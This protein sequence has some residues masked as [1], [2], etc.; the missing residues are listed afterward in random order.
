[1]HKLRADGRVCQA[2]SCCCRSY[3]RD[4]NIACPGQYMPSRQHNIL[5]NN[6]RMK[7]S[8]EAAANSHKQNNTMLTPDLVCYFRVQ[9]IRMQ[10]LCQ[11]QPH[12]FSCASR[13]PRPSTAPHKLPN[14]HTFNA[15]GAFFTCNASALLPQPGSL[16][17]CKLARGASHTVWMQPRKK[18][19]HHHVT[20][21][22]ISPQEV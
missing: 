17:G 18:C 8:T 13:K 9:C 2:A 6:T 16:P 21:Q 5:T 12:E 10:T 1:M 4:L 20:Y 19:H 14:C 3:T 22:A 15:K 11:Q 7:V